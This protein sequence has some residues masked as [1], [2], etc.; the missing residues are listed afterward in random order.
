MPPR[1]HPRGTT[2]ILAMILL[3]ILAAIGVAAVRLG[4]QERVNA[5]AK[6]RRDMLVACAHAARIRLF[7]M[8]DAKGP[9]YMQSTEIPAS[10]TLPD[11]T[12]LTAPAVPTGS[13]KDGGTVVDIVELRQL[14][15]AKATATRD[16]TNTMIDPRALSNSLGYGILA[17][18]R[19]SKGRELL[20]E[21]QIKFA[22]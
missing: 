17:R 11:G 15:T 14:L 19:D 1:A 2:L 10:I 12:E 22:L 8:L 13:P 20:A 3:A 4:S 9:G 16:L 18:C 6:G 7:E 5:S 21:F